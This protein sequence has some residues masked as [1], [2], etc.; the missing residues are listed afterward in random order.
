MTGTLDLMAQMQDGAA[1]E[2]K[3]EWLEW[4]EF[5]KV[6][7]DMLSVLRKLSCEPHH[8]ELQ[9]DLADRYRL[10]LTA[11]VDLRRQ[12][13]S[14]LKNMERV[15]LPDMPQ[16]QALREGLQA[17]AEAQEDPITKRWISLRK[18][19]LFNKEFR[20]Y[21]HARSVDHWQRMEDQYKGGTICSYLRTP[22]EYFATHPFDVLIKMGTLRSS[23]WGRIPDAV[24]HSPRQRQIFLLLWK[25]QRI[26][27]DD[28]G[29]EALAAFGEA[30]CHKVAWE[31]S[32]TPTPPPL[33]QNGAAQP[34]ATEYPD[35]FV[36]DIDSK[37]Q[38]SHGVV[39]G[40]R[41]DLAG[42]WSMLAAGGSRVRSFACD[43]GNGEL[44]ACE[45]EP[46]A[47]T[48]CYLV[49]FGQAEALEAAHQGGGGDL[50]VF[51]K[52]ALRDKLDLMTSPQDRSDF[53]LRLRKR[54]LD[55]ITLTGRLEAWS[56][57]DPACYINPRR[58][59]HFKALIEE[60]G[61][62]PYDWDKSRGPFWKAA[63]EE[64]SR[65]NGDAIAEGHARERDAWKKLSDLLNDRADAIRAQLA[66][67][68][69][70]P[71]RIQLNG[72]MAELYRVVETKVEI[73]FPAHIA[74]K[75][76][77]SKEVSECLG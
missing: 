1:R 35:D 76:M 36:M 54:G 12:A 29:L 24:L 48:G 50:A 62:E 39:D 75:I 13:S 77:A 28:F 53:D 68:P 57:K 69:P 47:L 43:P 59:L 51:W 52:K 17:L 49:D 31:C 15:K 8:H 71:V 19:R 42:G 41:I 5:E 55:L 61:C 72:K 22:A 40:V 2:L 70:G 73:G 25:G 58:M 20:V 65:A 21:S 27:E 7:C 18:H 63:W 14:L 67:N 64:I 9:S 30:H 16:W 44:H 37:V 26:K 10:W 3:V 6:Q 46:K 34:H 56:K 33:P 38:T 74:R 23:G 11:P 60:L 66:H 32:E 4:P 45:R